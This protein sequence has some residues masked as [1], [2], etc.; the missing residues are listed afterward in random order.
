[1]V[2]IMKPNYVV[3]AAL[4]KSKFSMRIVLVV[5]L[6]SCVRLCDLM[7]CSMPGSSVLHSLP[8]FAQTH[9]IQSSHPLSSPSP[10]AFNLSQHQGL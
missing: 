7:D 9:A 2:R 4:V 10:P 6:L 1:M 3:K 5:Q 8:N